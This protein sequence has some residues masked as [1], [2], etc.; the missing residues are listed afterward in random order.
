MSAK[1]EMYIHI[2]GW[3]KRRMGHDAQNLT[4]SGKRRGPVQSGAS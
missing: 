4:S 1:P 3:N 2:K